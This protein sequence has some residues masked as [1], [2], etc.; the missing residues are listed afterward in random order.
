M[1]SENPIPENEFK[2][3]SL[4]FPRKI[5][6]W[7]SYLLDLAYVLIILPSDGILGVSES[8]VQFDIIVLPMP[9][10][11]LS[12]N[13]K[14]QSL[15]IPVRIFILGLGFSDESNFLDESNL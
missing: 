3:S 2:K 12:S 10:L 5:L 13:L 7:P 4:R 11:I 6:Y 1:S 14:E 9:F 15:R 8:S